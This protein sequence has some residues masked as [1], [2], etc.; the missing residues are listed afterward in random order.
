MRGSSEGY[1]PVGRASLK[2]NVKAVLGFYGAKY[3]KFPLKADA[4]AYVVTT[5]TGV[6]T[7]V[8]VSPA[9]STSSES[10]SS[11]RATP[12]TRTERSPATQLVASSKSDPQS[13]S[14]FTPKTPKVVSPKPQRGVPMKIIPWT[15]RINSPDIKDESVW[16]VVYSDGAC[17]NNGK[18]NAIAG[19]GVWFGHNDPK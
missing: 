6:A 7:S 18:P 1:V 5:S 10:P 14:M 4:E 19:V 11:K 15:Q 2:L 16:D 8:I 17:K 3:K 9:K 12:Y 13:S